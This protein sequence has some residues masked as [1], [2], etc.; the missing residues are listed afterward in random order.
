LSEAQYQDF[1]REVQDVT[2]QI[3]RTLY[4]NESLKNESLFYLHNNTED[5]PLT[6]TVNAMIGFRVITH[7]G[8]IVRT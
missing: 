6:D 3:G 1:I 4:N 8:I 7:I 5:E 2:N